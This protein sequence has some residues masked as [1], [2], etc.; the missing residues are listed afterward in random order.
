LGGS[1][2]ESSTGSASRSATHRHSLV[3]PSVR[4]AAAP[5]VL[6]PAD[7]TRV[8]WA[9]AHWRARMADTAAPGR[10]TWYAA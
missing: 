10:W 9:P 6:P 5:A 1:G 3:R 7:P 4:S 2:G 8:A